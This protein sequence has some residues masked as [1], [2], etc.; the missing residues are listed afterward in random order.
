MK[1]KLRKKENFYPIKGFKKGKY[2]IILLILVL[3]II[4]SFY[5]LLYTNYFDVKNIEVRGNEH[6][7][8]KE[9]IRL[10]NLRTGMNIFKFNKEKVEKNIQRNSFIKN[11]QIERK[12]PDT[13]YIYTTE[14]EITSIIA[15]N[16]G[17]FLYLDE[18][19][20]VMDHKETLNTYNKPII[21]GLED[22]SFIIN[23]SI[24]INPNWLRRSIL[25]TISLLKKN[26]LIYEISEIHILENFDIHLYTNDGSVINIGNSSILKENI[27][28]LKSFLGQ[29]HQKVII[30]I[31]HGGDPVCKPRRN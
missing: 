12:L 28:F 22:V 27:D 17:T 6:I 16:D 19:G 5:F 18:E 10:S 4:F 7:E 26:D 21:T 2:G 3:T 31:S 14:R 29:P 25:E 8:K 11:V 15:Y 13:I 24:E 20:I 1:K 9:V 30:D 23:N